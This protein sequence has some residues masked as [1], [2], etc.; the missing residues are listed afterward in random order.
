MKTWMAHRDEY[1]D[2]L[3]R[4]DGRGFSKHYSYCGGCKAPDPTYRCK[5][6]TCLGPSLFC[7]RC[8]VDKHLALPCHLIEVR[9]VSC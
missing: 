4:L 6:Q 2:E 1:L 5:S 3:L 9:H 8:I 7:Q